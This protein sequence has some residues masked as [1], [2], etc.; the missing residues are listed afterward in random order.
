MQRVTAG[1]S[2]A[3]ALLSKGARHVPGDPPRKP[4]LSSSPSAG[5]SHAASRSRS[6]ARPS[7]SGALVPPPSRRSFCNATSK[8][9]KSR[10]GTFPRTGAL[11]TVLQLLRP[12]SCCPDCQLLR[13]G[14]GLLRSSFPL[15]RAGSQS[16]SARTRCSQLSQAFSCPALGSSADDV[17]PSV[18]AVPPLLAQSSRGEV[19][20]P[21]NDR[22]LT[23]WY[24]GAACEPLQPTRP[25]LSEWAQ[26]R[27]CRTPA[28]RHRPGHCPSPRA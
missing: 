14:G 26:H 23:T 25:N 7:C 12:G 11:G 28:P 24:V 5:A 6:T 22:Q 2:A 1:Q 8:S 13:P 9:C 3:L 20:V 21:G 18:L 4:P 19:L 17:S 27:S 16:C 10:R 15:A